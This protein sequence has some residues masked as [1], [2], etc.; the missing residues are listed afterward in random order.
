MEVAYS[1][2]YPNTYIQVKENL[3]TSVH[4][5]Q[6]LWVGQS[7]DKYAQIIGNQSTE[8]LGGLKVSCSVGGRTQDLN[9]QLG[10]FYGYTPRPLLF[11]WVI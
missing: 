10:V 8:R 11:A 6:T 2:W 9:S 1:E 3:L 4:S 7:Q 5:T